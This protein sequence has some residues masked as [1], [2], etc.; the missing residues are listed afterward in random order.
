LIEIIK[1]YFSTGK[2]DWI[3]IKEIAN[4]MEKYYN[5]LNGETSRVFM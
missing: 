4:I 1:K 3:I 2:P 5:G